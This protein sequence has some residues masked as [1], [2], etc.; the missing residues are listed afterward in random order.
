M[1]RCNA[2]GGKSHGSKQPP[3]GRWAERARRSSRD[4]SR[5]YDVLEGLTNVGRHA[6]RTPPF[7][8]RGETRVGDEDPL[9]GSPRHHEHDGRGLRH[10]VW[11]DSPRR[12]HDRR[13]PLSEHRL[14]TA[15]SDARPGSGL[16]AHA[17][18]I[19]GATELAH[20]MRGE[21]DIRP[22]DGARAAVGCALLFYTVFFKQNPAKIPAVSPR[23]TVVPRLAF[24]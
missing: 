20:L 7:V 9:S 15:D 5:R 4:G 17:P 22:W 6:P 19:H 13:N 14:P 10:D 16:S 21:R 2:L 1:N 12:R 11:N 24:A 18:R 3:S 23:K 8:V